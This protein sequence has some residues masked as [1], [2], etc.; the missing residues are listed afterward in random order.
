MSN[1]TA[2][3]S[4]RERISLTRNVFTHSLQFECPECGTGLPISPIGEC[5][6]C[7]AH[8][9]LEAVLEVPG[10]DEHIPE[11]DQ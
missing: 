11:D 7:G 9:R 3:E 4:K 8:I 2:D 6:T 5:S 10:M 1:D